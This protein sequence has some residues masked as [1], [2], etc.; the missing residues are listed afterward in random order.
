MKA[1]RKFVLATTFAFATSV[2][3]TTWA[4]K[5]AKPSGANA[6][7]TNAIAAEASPRAGIDGVKFVEPSNGAT[8]GTKFKVK[9]GVNGFTIAPLGTMDKGTGH[10]HLIVDGG[11]I[12]EGKVVPTDKTHLHF[13]KGQTE[14]EIELPKGKHKLTLQFADG[15]H[16]SYGP[17][18]SETIEVNVQ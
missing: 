17:A 4:A 13:G 14:T 1:T 6:P 18:M 2:A 10:H 3:A 7:E 15:A 5:A 11:P 9:M 8:V 12:A 16:R